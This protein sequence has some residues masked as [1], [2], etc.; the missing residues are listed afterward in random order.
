MYLPQDIINIDTVF[1]L[2][3]LKLNE[4]Y[5]LTFVPSNTTYNKI[6]QFDFKICIR[7]KVPKYDYDNLKDFIDNDRL[8]GMSRPTFV[9]LLFT[10][11]YYKRE[12]LDVKHLKLFEQYTPLN[13]VNICIDIL[14][15]FCNYDNVINYIIFEKNVDKKLITESI[16]K[17]INPKI[18]LLA[19]LLDEDASFLSITHFYTI[20]NTEVARLFFVH[21]KQMSTFKKIKLILKSNIL[22]K[23]RILTP[24]LQNHR[25]TK[26]QQIEIM[27]YICSNMSR[28][29]D[30][31]YT[32][33]F[34]FLDHFLITIC[35]SK[36][37]RF[38]ISPLLNYVNHN[39]L[40]DCLYL[41]MTDTNE[42]YFPMILKHVN[43]GLIDHKILQ[44]IINGEI[45][46]KSKCSVLNYD[47]SY[48]QGNNK[49][50]KRKQLMMNSFNIIQ[51]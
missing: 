44:Q 35:Q 19:K 1:N 22:D 18:D 10:E 16:I 42:Y 8:Y 28:L 47:I 51:L 36:V 13:L 31:F 40:V 24:L 2:K 32:N 12:P 5:V 25:I 20:Y 26:D 15:T 39:V 27:Y 29:F 34:V 4:K 48:V 49:V 41:C 21:Y 6:K 23:S 46:A 45:K 17:A 43:H 7:Y 33:G 50:V 14:N 30:I 11:L 9:N 38:D 3:K 37:Y